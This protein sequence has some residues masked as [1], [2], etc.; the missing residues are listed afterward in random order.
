MIKRNYT[1]LNDI[2]RKMDLWIQ[3]T[4]YYLETKMKNKAKENDKYDTGDYIRSF[5]SKKKWK[6]K[7]EVWNTKNYARVVEYWRKPWKYP[8]FDA[9]VGRTARKFNLWWKTKK[10]SQASSEL[11]SAVFLVARSIKR[12]GIKPTQIM[13]ETI[14]EEK[15]NLTKI[16]KSVF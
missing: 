1:V 6:Y 9:L 4:W 13:T 15:P 16:F 8:N 14:I 12:K 2:K 5:Y 3:K 10:Y 11:K 7:V